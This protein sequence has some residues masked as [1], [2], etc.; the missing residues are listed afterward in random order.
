MKAKEFEEVVLYR[1]RQE[2][3]HGRATMGRYG[4]QGAFRKGKP[5][6]VPYFERRFDTAKREEIAAIVK[7]LIEAAMESADAWQPLQSLPDFEGIVLPRGSQFVLDA[8]VCN[9][10]SFPLDKES[11]S[12]SR[13]LRHM[14][15][16]SR[17]GA[18]CFYLIH[19]PERVLS[20]TTEEEQT[21][22]FPIRDDHP[23]W[24]AF[25]RGEVKRITRADC[26]EYA[27]R[28]PWNLLPGGRTTRP[29]VLSAVYELAARK[30]G[31]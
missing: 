27:V 15:N 20:K 30:N 28:V 7:D 10:A 9:Q 29:D 5:L 23:F 1:M 13:Q 18:V 24:M 21:W 4:V 16:R 2:E 12:Q 3:E 14:L 17:F 25:D 11:K 26:A 22:A 31:K 6:N 19:F 8:K